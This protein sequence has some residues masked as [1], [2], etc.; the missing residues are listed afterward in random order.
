M[1]ID[2]AEVW[3]YSTAVRDILVAKELDH[4]NTLRIVDLLGSSTSEDL[5]KEEYLK[6]A[7][8][9]RDELVE[10][11][12]PK[13]FDSREAVRTDKD[14]C[15]TYRGYIKFL[16][17]DLRHGRFAK[18]NPSKR[19]FKDAIEALA[20]KMIARGKVSSIVHLLPI[21]RIDSLK[22]LGFRSCYR[23]QMQGLRSALNPSFRWAN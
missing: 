22:F 17:K 9:Y 20:L 13:D 18:E 2:D 15:M 1:L 4:V 21:T 14:T 3:D 11:Y 10:K 12:G 19:Q 6:N 8:S 23:G 7:S 5:T 16:T